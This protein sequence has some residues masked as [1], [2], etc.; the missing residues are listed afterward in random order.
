MP[1]A[2][3]RCAAGLWHQCIE[4]LSCAGDALDNAMEAAADK[5]QFWTLWLQDPCS[6]LLLHGM[7]VVLDGAI[8]Q[9]NAGGRSEGLPVLF[10]PQHL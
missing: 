8:F 3:Q 2:P 5:G 1:R 10:S 6:E 4:A 9:L 7:Q